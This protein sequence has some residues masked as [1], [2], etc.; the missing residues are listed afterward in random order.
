MQIPFAKY[1]ALRNDFLVIEGPLRGSFASDP[2]RLAKSICDRRSGIG[3]DGIL[4][5]TP[6]KRGGRRIDVYNADGSWAERSGNGLRIAGLHELRRKKGSRRWTFEMGGAV[7]EVRLR[8]SAPGGARMI[9]AD[10][11]APDFAAAHVPVRSDLPYMIQVPLRL[12]DVDIPVTCLSVGNPHTVLFVD[13]FDFDWR[14]LG[15]D[16]ERHRAFPR[17]T[18]VEFV[19][20]VSRRKLRVAEWERGAGATGSSGTGAAAAVAAAVIS[21]FADRACEVV[22][23]SGSLFVDW[24]EETDIIELTGPVTYVGGGVFE[25]R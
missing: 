22:F 7:S 24:H 19:K 21:G 11:G 16:V 4:L 8:P 18:N 5:L 12:D 1:H 23:D 9:A 25:G 10:M 2:S 20:I 6:L 3:A 15:A 14:T 13:D 17:R